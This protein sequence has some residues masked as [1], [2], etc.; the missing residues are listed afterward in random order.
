MCIGLTGFSVL[1]IPFFF[2]SALF[3]VG[4]LAN[5]GFKLG[6]NFSTCS[7]DTNNGMSIAGNGG[8][9][10]MWQHCGP[11]ASL[12]HLVIAFCFMIPKLIMEAR[13]I[14]LGTLPKG[15][16]FVI[17]YYPLLLFEMR[18]SILGISQEL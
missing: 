11:T 14:Q 13:C 18:E 17:Y 8:C 7:A 4:N 5:D 15:K 16:T 9:R 1:L 2:S 12:F 10:R 3:K 6:R